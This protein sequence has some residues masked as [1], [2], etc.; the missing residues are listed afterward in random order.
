M[1]CLTHY[2]DFSGCCVQNGLWLDFQFQ[3]LHIKI[4]DVITLTLT[5]RRSGK[6]LKIN[7]FP[8]THQKTEFI[9]QR[10]TLKPGD[11]REYGVTAKI[12]TPGAEAAG[13]I[14][15]WEHLSG[16]FDKLPE[17]ECGLA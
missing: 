2:R 3:L 7:N 11:T 1:T 10:S 14:N 12:W 13:A 9:G 17:A 16:N 5:I 8:W 6:N 4:L 15:W